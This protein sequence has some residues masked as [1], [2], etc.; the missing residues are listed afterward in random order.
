M[1]WFVPRVLAGLAA[2]AL[3]G[4]PACARACRGGGAGDLRRR[5]ARR[6]V[7]RG[8]STVFTRLAAELAARAAM[9]ARRRATPACGASSAI[10][11]NARCAPREQG[12]R[13]ERERLA[14]FLSAI[15]ASP[16]GVLLLD[17]R[18]Q[19]DWCNAQAA[20]HFGL[21]PQRD[22]RQ[23]VTN[24]VRA[25][26]FVAYLQAGTF[27]EPVPSRRRAAKARCRCWSGAT[28]TT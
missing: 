8:R 22:R 3:G 19:I 15:E 26:A 23:R 12:A 7:D 17:A 20:D 2:M 14:Q 18:D 1:G 5:H 21:D 24:L 6:R 10:A 25:P 4:L 9:T 11:S 13:I 27:D 16:N 28:A